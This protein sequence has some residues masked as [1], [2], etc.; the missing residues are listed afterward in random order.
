MARE[1]DIPTRY[2]RAA[3]SRMP[4][5][6]GGSR[7]G[8]VSSFVQSKPNL[9]QS[10]MA[11]KSLYVNRL[12]RKPWLSDARKQSQSKPIWARWVER[13]VALYTLAPNKAN[14]RR[15]CAKNEDLAQKQ[16]Q[17]RAA[18]PARVQ[19]RRGRAVATGGER[20]LTRTASIRILQPF[21]T[22]ARTPSE[23][24]PCRRERASVSRRW[25]QTSGEG[26]RRLG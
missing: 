16:S 17:F 21:F 12:R 8:A 13:P 23:I 25:G 4:A 2:P 24:A 3:Y 19:I 10:Q 5:R 9:S 1:A 11:D 15:F 14:S 18:G 26:L 6:Q 22:E 20:E 7:V